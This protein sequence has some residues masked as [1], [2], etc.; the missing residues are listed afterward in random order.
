MQ[1]ALKALTKL[2]SV[3]VGA[4][5]VSGAPGTHQEWGHDAAVPTAGMRSAERTT[6]K[7][8]I[9]CTRRMIPA[10]FQTVR[11]KVLKSSSNAESTA[12]RGTVSSSLSASITCAIRTDRSMGCR[13]GIRRRERLAV[14]PLQLASIG[15]AFREPADLSPFSL[16]G[17][18]GEEPAPPQI[19]RHA[20]VAVAGDRTGV[21]PRFAVRP[22]TEERTIAAGRCGGA[23]GSGRETTAHRLPSEPISRLWA[24]ACLSA[25]EG[26]GWQEAIGAAMAI[27]ACV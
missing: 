21:E 6:V 8:D 19:R 20:L 7:N 26:S 24:D 5:E 4:G 23:G 3:P 10:F 9:L 15:Q 25:G 16:D 12:V 11:A 17:L 13:H 27:S 14:P 1:T 2:A 22:E 18:P